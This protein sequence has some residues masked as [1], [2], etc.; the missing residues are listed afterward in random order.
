[1]YAGPYPG[2]VHG[3]NPAICQNG[4]KPMLKPF[5]DEAPRDQLL[6]EAREFQEIFHHERKSLAG[7]LE[8]RIS[9][10]EK[11]VAATGLY[12]HTHE[13]LQA[14]AALAWRNASKCANRK[15]WNTIEVY[16]RRDVRTN[17]GMFD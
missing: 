3:R 5:G 2:Y 4:C 7:V 14:G 8:K 1:V 15:I 12:R 9:E 13:E 16:D 10:I 11:E 17:P 6:R